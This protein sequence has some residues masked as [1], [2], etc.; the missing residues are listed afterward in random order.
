MQLSSTGAE[1]R[2]QRILLVDD[3]PIVLFGI[4]LLLSDSA[5]FTVC[6]EASD[7]ASLDDQLDAIRPDIVVLDMLLG[8]HDGVALIPDIIARHPGIRVIVYSCQHEELAGQRAIRAGASGYVSKIGGLS[9][10][11]N[12]LVAVASGNRY[13]SDAALGGRRRDNSPTEARLIDS[14]SERELQVLRLTGQGLTLQ[15]IAQ[16]LTVS[17]KTVGTYRERLKVKLGVDRVQ[18]LAWVAQDLR[19]QQAASLI[20]PI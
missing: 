15:Q 16:E 6:G 8:D 13:F 14:L 20:R 9:Q 17:I 7:A 19:E 2:P 10:L 3:H 11:L 12:A 1:V 18:E 4:T 5:Y